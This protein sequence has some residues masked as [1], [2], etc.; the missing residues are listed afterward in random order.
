MHDQGDEPDDQENV[1]QA[2]GD[3]EDEPAQEPGDKTDDEE[4]Q[5]QRE[6][7]EW[8][9]F[10]PPQLGDGGVSS[11]SREGILLGPQQPDCLC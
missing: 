11:S 8:S 7:H 10:R 9:P 3:V 6:E 1:N 4:D 2:S 5:K